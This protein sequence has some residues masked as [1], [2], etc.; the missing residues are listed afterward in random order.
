METKAS[1]TTLGRL[2][3][4]GRRMLIPPK[5]PRQRQR[6]RN[7]IGEG[8]ISL[9]DNDKRR[10]PRTRF[11]LTGWKLIVVG[12]DLDEPVDC[13]PCVERRHLTVWLNQATRQVQNTLRDCLSAPDYFLPYRDHYD[14]IHRADLRCL[15]PQRRAG[16]GI[17]W[18]TT[19]TYGCFEDA[20]VRVPYVDNLHRLRLD[21][22]R[23]SK[24]DCYRRTKQRHRYSSFS[25]SAAKKLRPSINSTTEMVVPERSSMIPDACR[26]STTTSRARTLVPGYT[27]TKAPLGRERLGTAFQPFTDHTCMISWITRGDKPPRHSAPLES[28]IGK[29]RP[30][31]TTVVDDSEELVAPTT[32]TKKRTGGGKKKGGGKKEKLTAPEATDKVEVKRTGKRVSFSVDVPDASKTDNG[33]AM[34]VS[35]A[36]GKEEVLTALGAMNTA[37]KLMAA[38]IKAS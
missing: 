32:T 37:L 30:A 18:L 3:R 8:R 36:P 13:E 20:T 35:A 16:D 2:L 34:S 17:G 12:D 27:C 11:E 19:Q 25:S 24:A 1:E 23:R 29:K 28:I 5:V 33:V 4:L 15:A 6:K 22:E 38:T 26:H 9:D 10:R 14:A 7:R 31:I 21:K